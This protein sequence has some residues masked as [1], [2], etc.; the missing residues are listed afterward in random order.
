MKRRDFLIGA[1]ALGLAAPTFF[2]AAVSPA[3]ARRQMALEM[4]VFL[5]DVAYL[6]ARRSARR[7]AILW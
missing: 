4:L 6:A 7:R 3:E 5:A 2:K 1:S